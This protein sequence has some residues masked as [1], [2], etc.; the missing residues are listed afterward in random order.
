ML[1]PPLI[2]TGICPQ[3]LFTM[4]T[5]TWF[6]PSLLPRQLV[7]LGYRLEPR[8]GDDSKQREGDA[9][10]IIIWQKG[11]EKPGFHYKCDGPAPDGAWAEGV[12]ATPSEA[13]EDWLVSAEL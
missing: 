5:P 4:E 6:S 9:R 13:L 10:L 12:G 8:E 1:E 7:G 2:K 3:T 11:Y